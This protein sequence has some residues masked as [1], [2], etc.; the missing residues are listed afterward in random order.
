MIGR[1]KQLCYLNYLLTKMSVLD[2]LIEDKREALRELYNQCTDR[3]QSLFNRMYNSVDEVPEDRLNWAIKQCENTI[4]N[5]N[6]K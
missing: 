5:N 2:K 1:Q 4:K 6:T 3:Q